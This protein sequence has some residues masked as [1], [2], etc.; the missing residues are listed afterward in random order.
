MQFLANPSPSLQTFK[1]CFQPKPF[2]KGGAKKPNTDGHYASHVKN[3]SIQYR[4]S[5]NFSLVDIFRRI[6]L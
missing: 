6:F 1:V 2:F 5:G 3:S 4:V